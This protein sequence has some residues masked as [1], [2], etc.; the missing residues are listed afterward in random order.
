MKKFPCKL[1]LFII[2]VI[3]CQLV[4]PLCTYASS[5]MPIIIEAESFE[6]NGSHY[7]EKFYD[8]SASG[9]YCLKTVSY[10]A[11][12]DVIPPDYLEYSFSVA[13]AGDYNI[14]IRSKSESTGS[15]S[16]FYSGVNSEEFV[17]RDGF[18]SD[19][20]NPYYIW[21]RLEKSHLNPGTYTIKFKR[22]EG[23][24]ARGFCFDKILITDK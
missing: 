18:P 15:D 7:F 5:S 16:I 8:S 1:C 6:V 22:R 11:D 9:E 4:L 10:K 23:T 2:G 3:L 24:L 21:T 20:N 13:T 17:N 14:W 19:R 12:V